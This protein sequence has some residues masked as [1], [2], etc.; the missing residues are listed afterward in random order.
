[1]PVKR[2]MVGCTSH[3]LHGLPTMHTRH[4]N[5]DTL[6][7]LVALCHSVTSPMRCELSPASV[8]TSMLDQHGG[9][10]ALM[11]HEPPAKAMLYEAAATDESQSCVA[12]QLLSLACEVTGMPCVWYAR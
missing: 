10:A 3:Q 12:K 4:V 6:V 9:E 7:F 1:M 8:C 11:G 5:K 2:G